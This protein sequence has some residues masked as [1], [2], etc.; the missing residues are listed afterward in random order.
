VNEFLVN[1]L[2]AY[3]WT[4]I[5]SNAGRIV[6]GNLAE[7]P[8]SCSFDNILLFMAGALQGEEEKKTN[9]GKLQVSEDSFKI[10]ET[11]F[12][13]CTKSFFFTHTSNRTGFLQL[14]WFCTKT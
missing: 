7:S 11:R 14:I 5:L 4:V 13:P 12:L 2:G 1:T 8:F 10:E 9:R 3:S 6:F